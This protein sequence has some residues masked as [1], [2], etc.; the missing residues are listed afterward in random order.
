MFYWYL[1]IRVKHN[2]NIMKQLDK[3]LMILCD[4][5]WK[6]CTGIKEGLAISK[7]QFR[8][9]IHFLQNQQLVELRNGG[10]VITSKGKKFIE[11]P[12]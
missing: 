2:I 1:F 12:H 10:I 7:C 5:N 6:D 3:I 11:L 9:V 4:S 8:E